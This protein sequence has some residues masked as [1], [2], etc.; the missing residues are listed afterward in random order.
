MADLSFCF[1][2]DY[3][4]T[5]IAS[6]FMVGRVPETKG[7]PLDHI[8]IFSRKEDAVA[9]VIELAHAAGVNAWLLEHRAGHAELWTPLS[10]GGPPGT[11]GEPS[12]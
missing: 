5:P 8:A 6:G 2:G 7:G 1:P 10:T 4:L 11:K 3:T 9:S 12:V